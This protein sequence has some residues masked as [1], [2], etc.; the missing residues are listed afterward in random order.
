MLP[1]GFRLLPLPPALHVTAAVAPV[2]TQLFAAVQ[3]D[4]F[5]RSAIGA[6]GGEECWISIDQLPAMVL[7]S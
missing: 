7:Y 3:L 1:D 2:M 6:L 4:P 5:D